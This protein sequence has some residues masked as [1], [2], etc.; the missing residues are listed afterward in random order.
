MSKLNTVK[1]VKQQRLRLLVEQDT[2]EENHCKPCVSRACEQCAIY[3]RLR[4]IGSTLTT[5]SQEGRKLKAMSKLTVASY[6]DLKAQG[7]TDKAIMQQFGMY[8]NKFNTWK[9]ENGLTKE[10]ER[11]KLETT[12]PVKNEQKVIALEA[13]EKREEI[14]RK[15]I[16]ELK[17]TIEKLIEEKKMLQP[18]EFEEE[19]N[20]FQVHLKDGTAIL[21]S[22]E[23]LEMQ[24]DHSLILSDS[25]QIKGIFKENSY[26]YA[27]KI[28]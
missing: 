25:N 13:V 20:M 15:E 11:G 8:A 27:V 6:Q 12:A 23:Q 28:E 1:A 22:A 16:A 14:F 5:L 10:K 18:F 4:A 24:A 21:I 19:G 26:E 2:I 7:K 17:A 9:K 3:T